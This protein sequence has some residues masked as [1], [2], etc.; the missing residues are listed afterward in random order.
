MSGPGVKGVKHSCFGLVM[1]SYSGGS[2]HNPRARVSSRLIKFDSDFRIPQ[3]S[4]KNHVQLRCCLKLINF[5]VHVMSVRRK[6]KAKK[7]LYQQCRLDGR[8]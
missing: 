4:V 2:S 8:M 7:T 3:K 5:K 1:C 6:V